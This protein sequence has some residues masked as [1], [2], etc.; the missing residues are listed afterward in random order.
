MDR[1]S[2]GKYSESLPVDRANTAG[3]VPLDKMIP[4][5]QPLTAPEVDSAAMMDTSDCVDSTLLEQ[6]SPARKRPHNWRSIPN[7]L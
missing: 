6:I 4:L 1:E 7:S 5:G 2:L 3:A